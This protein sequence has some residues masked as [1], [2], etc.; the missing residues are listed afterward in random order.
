MIVYNIFMLY[1]TH[2]LP[3]V[4]W[5]SIFGGVGKTGRSICV[6]K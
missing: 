1:I 5:K 6:L 2:G 4:V 3:E